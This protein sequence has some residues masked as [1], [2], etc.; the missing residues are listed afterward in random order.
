MKTTSAPAAYDS[1][2]LI[3]Q[4]VLQ[5]YGSTPDPRLR[6]LMLSLIKHLHAFAKEVKLTSAEWFAA[7]QLLEETGKWCAPGRN[8]FI[9]FSDALGLSMLTVTRT[10]PDLKVQPSPRCWAP[11]WWRARR[12]SRWAPIS[13]MAPRGSRF[14][15]RAL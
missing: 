10:T 2:D 5:R 11:S 6:E 12:S 4:E 8:E 3:T 7:M 1:T 9:I 14:T 13:A 15:H